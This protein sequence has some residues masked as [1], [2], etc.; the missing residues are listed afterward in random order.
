MAQVLTL[1]TV[2]SGQGL[3]ITIIGDDDSGTAPVTAHIAR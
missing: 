2:R 1:R 3:P